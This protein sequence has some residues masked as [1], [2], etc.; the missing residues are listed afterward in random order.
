MKLCFPVLQ[1]AGIESNVHNHF[2]SAP[3][4]LVVDTE[5]RAVGAIVN[6]DRRHTHGACNPVQ[7]LDNQRIDAV[8]AGGIGA[9]A[10]DKLHRAG[11]KV[12]HA[13]AQTIQENLALFASE[14]LPE[15]TLR[16]TCGGHGG[17]GS[18]SH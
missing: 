16:H 5:T 13:Q 14:G 6:R 2:G 15:F 1:D 4:F 10:L 7:A 12:Y 8:I 11:I 9:G 18:C 3:V 17:D